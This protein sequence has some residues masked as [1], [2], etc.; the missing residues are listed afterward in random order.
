MHLTSLQ[1]AADHT[2]L[3][4]LTANHAEL[5]GQVTHIPTSEYPQKKVAK[6]LEQAKRTCGSE[7]TRIL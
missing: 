1:T 7:Y 2:K 5:L 3:A 4:E 6:L